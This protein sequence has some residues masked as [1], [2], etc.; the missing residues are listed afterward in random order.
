MLS[1]LVLMILTFLLGIYVANT[2]HVNLSDL[3]NST[4]ATV[5]KNH[6]S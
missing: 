3:M 1:K 4:Q 6:K 5:E 2:Y